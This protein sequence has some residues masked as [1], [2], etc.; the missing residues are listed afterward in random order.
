MYQQNP[1]MGYY[2]T[3]QAQYANP[4]SQVPSPGSP[5]YGQGYPPPSVPYPQPQQSTGMF[6][7]NLI[8]SLTVNAFTLHDTEEKTGHWFVLQDLSVRTEGT[9][10]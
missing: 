8:G 2:P 7:R 5:A 1:S 3:P 6:T 9:F 10:R 4:Y